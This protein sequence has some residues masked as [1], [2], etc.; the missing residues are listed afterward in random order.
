MKVA[1]NEGGIIME[2]EYY[3]FY[4][5]GEKAT[6]LGHAYQEGK[7][8]RRILNAGKFCGQLEVVLDEE[9]L[10][11]V[12]VSF[13][14]AENVEFVRKQLLKIGF[15][16]VGYSLC[17]Y[18]DAE[19]S[20]NE[21]M[22]ECGILENPETVYKTF[23]CGEREPLPEPTITKSVITISATVHEEQGEWLD[24]WIDCD[25]P[26]I[27]LPDEPAECEKYLRKFDIILVG[28]KW[29]AGKDADK[30]MEEC[31][32]QYQKITILD[33]K[34]K[35]V[36]EIFDRTEL[37][38]CTEDLGRYRWMSQKYGNVERSFADVLENAEDGDIFKHNWKGW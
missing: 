4:L 9:P 15:D 5:H 26:E 1:K 12:A 30:A 20:E 2:R 28:D 3:T 25:D 21:K 13:I 16:G 35:V 33:D 32:R 34:D 10:H 22:V 8:Y 19:C 17:S 37:L 7:C 29:F 11:V 36:A 24:W 14:E 6:K 18:S 31:Y 23:L 38:D 27:R